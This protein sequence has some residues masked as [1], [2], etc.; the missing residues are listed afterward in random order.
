MIKRYFTVAC[1][2]AALGASAVSASTITQNGTTTNTN[3]ANLSIGDDITFNEQLSHTDASSL[4]SFTFTATENLRVSF[5][6]MG[7]T[8]SIASEI[9]KVRYGY[10]NP[11]SLTFSAPVVLPGGTAFASGQLSQVNLL[12]GQSLQV[13][14]EEA[15]VLTKT[16]GTTSSFK[17][18]TVP[19]PAALP[20]LAGALGAMGIAR[21]KARKS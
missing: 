8:S 16:V 15:Q 5:I 20:L 11:P 12:K 6:A 18:S 10:S 3:T 19:V 1:L 14:F 21:R 7:A 2:A 13:F 17:T 4:Y 9:G